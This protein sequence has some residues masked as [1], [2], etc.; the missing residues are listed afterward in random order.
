MRKV[1]ALLLA[2]ITL[3]VSM[4]V[5]LAFKAP[6][7]AEVPLGAPTAYR[8]IYIHIPIAWSTYALFTAALIAAILY[9]VKEDAKY[10][11]I[12]DCAAK[13]GLVYGA[14]TLITGIAWSA[15]S[16]GAYWLW[17]PFQTAV[18]FLELA[19]LGYLVVRASIRDPDRARTVSA[20]Y[21]IAAYTPIPLSILISRFAKTVHPAFLKAAAVLN[22]AMKAPM[23][24]HALVALAVSFTIL[25]VYY[26][27]V[28]PSK[29]LRLAVPAVLVILGVIVGLALAVPFI[30][31]PSGAVVGRV[32]SA[33]LSNGVLKIEVITSAGEVYHVTY[34]GTPPI[35]PEW[36]LTKNLVLV[37]GAVKAPG[38]IEATKVVVVNA[39]CVAFNLAAYLVTLAAALIVAWWER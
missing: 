21:T 6:F 30:F 4:A 36:A 31:T 38:I 9:L 37:E 27:R 7:P 1:I 10:E 35:K 26:K 13:L 28:K 5:Y 24:I 11:K 14:S 15:E 32:S 18:L 12:M 20:V 29:P 17:D 33:E 22:P 8:N 16:W 19:F 2:L 34:S 39:P 23:Y 25:Y 3:D